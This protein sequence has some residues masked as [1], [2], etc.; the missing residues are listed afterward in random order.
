VINFKII[1]HISFVTYVC[2]SV[3]KK[4]CL[5]YEIDLDNSLYLCQSYIKIGRAVM[6]FGVIC[7]TWRTN[8]TEVSNWMCPFES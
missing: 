1:V 4:M 8:F 7:I 6:I 2:P 3:H 5:Y